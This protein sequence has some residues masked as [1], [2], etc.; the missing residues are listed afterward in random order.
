MRMS[1][2]VFGRH[3]GLPP[4]SFANGHPLNFLA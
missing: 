3:C 4:R 2:M 1:N